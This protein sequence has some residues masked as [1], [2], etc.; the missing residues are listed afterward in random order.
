MSLQNYEK[1][2]T[3]WLFPSGKWWKILLIMKLKIFFLLVSL[4][5]L[6]AAGY[7][8]D[9]RFNLKKNDVSL[10]EVLQELQQQSEYRFFYQKDIFQQADRANVDMK[11]V[12][13]RQILDEV[14]IRHGFSYE[15][16]DKVITIRKI[17]QQKTAGRKITGIVMDT[18]KQS[19]PGVTVLLKGTAL[20]VV[21]D[22]EGRF[23]IEIPE[24]DPI[25]LVFL[26]WDEKAGSDL[27][28][29]RRHSG[30]YGRRSY[31]NG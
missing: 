15:M 22:K 19:L 30:C 27:H 17:Q 21:T 11:N 20:G 28:W 16:I 10:T 6:Q 24:T 7:S 14:L 8:Q 2:A 4:G 5:T 26:C 25:V 23:N 12:S 13:L 9:S 29:T 18:R 3:C 1:N 31:R